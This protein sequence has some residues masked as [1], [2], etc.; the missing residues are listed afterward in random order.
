MGIDRGTMLLFFSIEVYSH[1]GVTGSLLAIGENLVR[2]RLPVW[3]ST[4]LGNF[5]DSN[6]L[7]TMGCLGL[8]LAFAWSKSTIIVSLLLLDNLM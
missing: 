7:S 5:W 1:L 6:I 2:A 4:F 8:N 3:A